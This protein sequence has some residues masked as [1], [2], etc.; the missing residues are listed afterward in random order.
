[1]N[2]NKIAS[3]Y[4][5]KSA[6]AKKADLLRLKNDFAKAAQKIYDEWDEAKIEELNEGGI[7]Q[8]IADAIADVLNHHGIETGT[9]S[10]SI[11]DQHVYAIAKVEEGVFEIDISPHTYER[12]GG[13]HWTK[14]PDVTFDAGD[15][16]IS[17]IDDD[18]AKFDELLESY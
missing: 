14:I 11:G 1:M 6:A 4:L 17:L 3:N 18:P 9:V 12:G 8:D 7:C 15:I 16:R 13:Y 2:A 5:R 10:Q